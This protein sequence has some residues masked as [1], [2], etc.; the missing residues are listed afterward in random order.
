[1]LLKNRND[2][3]AAVGAGTSIIAPGTCFTGNISSTSDLRIDGTIEGNVQSQSK[4]VIG[5]DG[6]VKGDITG[7]QVDVMGH[8]S[9]NV[10]ATEGIILRSKARVQG[11]INTSSLEVERGALL[12]GKCQ[13]DG[14][15]EL[16]ASAGAKA[17]MPQPGNKK[18]EPEPALSDN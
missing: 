8:V 6:H 1:M 4:V 17:K 10:F 5:K 15:K 7:V 18:N 11:H 9:G 3:E 2:Q 14:I 13:M 12:D 16:A